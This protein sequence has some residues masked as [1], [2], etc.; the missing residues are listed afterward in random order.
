MIFRVR[1]EIQFDEPVSAAPIAGYHRFREHGE[2]MFGLVGVVLLVLLHL[3]QFVGVGHHF[4]DAFTLA[5]PLFFAD[6]FSVSS[7]LLKN[8][9]APAISGLVCVI[10]E[11]LRV[12]GVIFRATERPK[13]ALLRAV[14]TPRPAFTAPEQ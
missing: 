12:C 2:Q 3:L 4:L 8:R 7:R 11:F 6:S 14:E 10:R 5:L 1:F 9:A 13:V